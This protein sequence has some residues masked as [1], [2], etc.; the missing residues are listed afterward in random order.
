MKAITIVGGGSAGWMT[1][2]T[3]IKFFPNK[4]ITVIESPDVPTVGVGEST[5]HQFT[6]WCELLEIDEKKFL[7]ETDGTYK[8]SIKF[9][10]FYKKG[11]SFHYPF[12]IPDE[13]EVSA[14]INS[15]W[16]AKLK[17]PKKLNSSYVETFYP[18]M[19][20]VNNNKFSDKLPYAFHFDSSKFGK[21]LKDNYCI[22][23][24]VKYIKEHVEDIQQDENGIVSLNKKHKADLYID[25]TGF[26]SLLLGETFKE[27]FESYSEMLPNDSAWATRLPYKNKK[28]EIVSY[29]NCTAIQNGWVWRVPLW[30]KIGTGYVYSSKF[31]DDDNALKQFK[32][33]LGVKNLQF[34]KIKSKVGI[35]K[36]LW[37]KNVCAIGLSAG[38]IEPLEGNG[39]FSV[40]EFLINLVRNLR[41]NK[42]SQFDKDNFN[43]FCREVFANFAEFVALHYALSHRDD[44]PYWKSILNTQWSETMLNRL[45]KLGD[46]IDSA[47]RNRAF[48]F[49]HSSMGGL[50]CIAA[51]MDWSPTDEISLLRYNSK[52]QLETILKRALIEVD[53]KHGKNNNVDLKKEK[54]LFNYLKEIHTI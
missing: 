22:P 46:G 13:T 18:Q 11:K 6:K 27:P 1:A 34:K 30:S 7:K 42:V 24:G 45:P 49:Q 35:Y 52:K 47:V 32:K 37:V 33:Y 25:C 9:T 41:R 26:K 2:A 8:L 39:L 15:W 21:W 53:C 43:F 38:F 3:L 28:T 23:R 5:L 20:Y 48:G 29:T 36:R 51:G 10:D 12:G 16:L 50:H 31:I 17:N 54:N 14:G 40:H 19:H 4:K 44:T